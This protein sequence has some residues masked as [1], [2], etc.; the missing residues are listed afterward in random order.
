MKR[1]LVLWT[2]PKHSGKT[3]SAA[4]L[5][6]KAK[7]EGFRVA[8]LLAPSIYLNH[9]LTGFE[10]VNIKTG[11]RIPLAERSQIPD[12]TSV[13]GFTFSKTGLKFG[14]NAL[15]AK[16]VKSADLIIVD[17][18]GPWELAGNGWRK[19]V[20]S[21][22]FGTNALLVLVVRNEIIEQV[23][24]LYKALTCIQLD[25]V[26]PHSITKVIEILNNNLRM[27]K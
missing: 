21:I 13:G 3:T 24:K 7:S 16:S 19:N 12:T 5:A 23:K 10:A 17:E 11:E 14:S 27:K 20:D 26:K 8:G 22:L 2:G 25:A 6:Q 4:E 9:H 15:D 1:K 18:F